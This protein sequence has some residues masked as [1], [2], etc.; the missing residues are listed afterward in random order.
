MPYAGF[1]FHGPLGG[2]R[3]SNPAPATSAS[4]AGIKNLSICA[5]TSESVNTEP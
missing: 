2:H 1:A 5:A 4:T 3:P